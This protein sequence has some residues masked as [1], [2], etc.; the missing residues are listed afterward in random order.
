MN[1]LAKYQV[2]GYEP[3]LD[4]LSVER[5]VLGHITDEHHAGR[6]PRNTFARLD[7]ELGEDPHTDYEE[8]NVDRLDAMLAELIDEGLVEERDNGTYGLTDA[9]FTELAN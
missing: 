6:G 8:G 1:W 4:R 3:V 2:E 7:Q 5:R 9:G